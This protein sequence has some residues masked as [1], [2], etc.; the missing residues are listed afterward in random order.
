MPASEDANRPRRLQRRGRGGL[1]DGLEPE[2][3]ERGSNARADRGGPTQ[4]P[5]ICAATSVFSASDAAR[6]EWVGTYLRDQPVARPKSRRTSG[7]LAM[8]S[9]GCGA[10]LGASSV[11]SLS[12]ADLL[13][14][15][16]IVLFVEGEGW[17]GYALPWPE[18]E[19]DSAESSGF[20]R[21]PDFSASIHTTQPVHHP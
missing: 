3:S 9:V 6:P 18:G 19:L 8:A 15:T 1:F 2:L 17:Q 13:L 4:A 16:V 20:T 10:A 21:Q 14:A 12:F 5:F 7:R 11:Y